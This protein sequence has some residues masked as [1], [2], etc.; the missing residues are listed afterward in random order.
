L[1]INS[2]KNTFIFKLFDEKTQFLDQNDALKKIFNSEKCAK[3]FNDFQFLLPIMQ[4]F[5]NF[6]Y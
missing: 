4:G 6:N 1:A 2:P 3:G 5:G